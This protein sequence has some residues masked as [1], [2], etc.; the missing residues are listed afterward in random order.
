MLMKFEVNVKHYE[1]YVLHMGTEHRDQTRNY[2]KST[3]V[4]NFCIQV[5][6]HQSIHDFISNPEILKLDNIDKEICD[7]GSTLSKLGKTLKDLNG[8]TLENGGLRILTHF[9]KIIEICFIKRIKYTFDSGL[10]HLINK[11]VLLVKFQKENI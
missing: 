11:E 9:S 5:L 6:C 3:N 7:M 8:K 1:N 4:I 10:F 2:K